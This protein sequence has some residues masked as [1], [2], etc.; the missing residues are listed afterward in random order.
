MVLETEELRVVFKGTRRQRQIVAVDG[1]TLNVKEGEVVGF[2][3][4]NGAGKTTTIKVLMGFIYP[5]SGEA[6]VLGYEAGSK[7]ARSRTGYLPEVALYYP[8]LT[9]EEILR[10][11]GRLQGIRS[12]ELKSMV[13]RLISLVGLSGFEKLRLRNYS[14]GMLQRIGLAQA[15]MGEPDLLVLDEVTSGLDPIGRRDLRGILMDFKNRGKTV[16]FSSH[17]LSEV[18]RIC[19]RI[20][21]INEGKAVQERSLQAILESRTTYRLRVEADG[22]LPT[23]LSDVHVTKS[24]D[25]CYELETGSR[26][27]YLK[28]LEQLQQSGIRIIEVESMQ[29]SLEDYF[30]EV[31]GHK[32]A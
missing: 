9:A 7:V 20:I 2:I 11:Y 13:P 21:L 23:T 25:R 12:G 8:F 17:E 32:V 15:I 22:V 26:E 3:G 24:S 6:R 14:R 18:S 10:A 4:P 5:T 16:F 31:I 19:D 1:L 27:A 29:P 28:V 30:V